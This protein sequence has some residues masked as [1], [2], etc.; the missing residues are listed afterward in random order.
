MSNSGDQQIVNQPGNDGN[1][2]N[3]MSAFKDKSKDCVRTL[4]K[5]ALSTK[6]LLVAGI[7]VSAGLIVE[8][9]LC[10]TLC[11]ANFRSYVLSFYYIV[12]GLL[13]IGAELKFEIISNYLR[14]LFSYSGRGI[15]YIFLGTVALGEQW[16]AI[17][18]ALFLI[19]AGALHV[20]AGCQRGG[21]SQ[22]N[23]STN[24]FEN[25]NKNKQNNNSNNNS[26]D[27]GSNEM[28]DEIKND[29]GEIN[30]NQVNV[31]ING[32]ENSEVIDQSKKVNPFADYED[33]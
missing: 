19:M 14:I 20:T 31:E 3:M 1:D 10:F 24:S 6:F 2:N 13:T 26:N 4:G 8:G 9:L 5:K 7:T 30:N 33:Y 11:D 29:D 16:W 12:F 25:N 32:N 15:W 21:S 28:N 27:N 17:L 22:T 23:D 18:I